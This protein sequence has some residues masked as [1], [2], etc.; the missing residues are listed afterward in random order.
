[1]LD[2]T[3]QQYL[4]VLLRDHYILE[5]ADDYYRLDI[6]IHL[7]FCVLLIA[8]RTKIME[9]RYVQIFFI[10]MVIIV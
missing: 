5:G 7:L 1:M 2:A 10:I 8:F 6:Y 9:L 3:L 4:A